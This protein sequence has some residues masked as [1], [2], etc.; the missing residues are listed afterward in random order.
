MTDCEDREK[1]FIDRYAGVW[2]V[3]IGRQ[4]TIFAVNYK[5]ALIVALNAVSVGP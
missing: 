1:A 3:I 5:Q 2:R 4:L